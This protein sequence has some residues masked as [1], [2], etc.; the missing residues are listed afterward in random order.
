[1]ND[2]LYVIKKEAWEEFC[3]K[4]PDYAG[5]MIPAPQRI[6]DRHDYGKYA[7]HVRLEVPVPWWYREK[8]VVL[9][10]PPLKSSTLLALR[11]L[12]GVY[13]LKGIDTYEQLTSDERALITR[14]ELKEILAWVGR[15]PFRK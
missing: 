5:R 7:D 10:D 4:N 6:T 9:A 11:N 12:L 14:E 1:M 15:R 8:D 2:E 13:S 3:K